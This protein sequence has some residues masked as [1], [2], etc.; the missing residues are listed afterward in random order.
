MNLENLEN[1]QGLFFG[2]TEGTVTTIGIIIGMFASTGS[3]KGI[4]SAVLAATLSDT[5]GDSIGLYYS[6]KARVT[7]KKEN[8]L[9]VVASMAA[10]KVII[11]II[12]LLPI[13]LLTNLNHCIIGSIIIATM[14]IVKSLTYLAEKR[15]ENINDFVIK[16][17]G[18][19]FIVIILTYLIGL[20]IDKQF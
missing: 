19:M 3:K 1:L 2:L 13:L 17:T 12:Y 8:S 10:I 14:V 6:E 11:S 16:N 20:F 15:K 7:S 5:F 9:A 4:I 18:L